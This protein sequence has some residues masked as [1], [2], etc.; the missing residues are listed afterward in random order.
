MMTKGEDGVVKVLKEAQN[1]SSDSHTKSSAREPLHKWENID[2]ENSVPSKNMCSENKQHSLDDNSSKNNQKEHLIYGNPSFLSRFI[3]YRSEDKV[4]CNIKDSQKENEVN[5]NIESSTKLVAFQSTTVV[6]QTDEVQSDMT[7]TSLHDHVN[8]SGTELM[9]D[10][11][12]EMAID[13]KEKGVGDTSSKQ[14]VKSSVKSHS[15]DST[16]KKVQVK[17]PSIRRVEEIRRRIEGNVDNSKTSKESK[18]PVPK[19]KNNRAD[20]KSKSTLD[21]KEDANKVEIRRNNSNTK[22]SPPRKVSF[23]VRSSINNGRISSISSSS[24]RSS[25]LKTAHM[26]SKSSNF[27]SSKVAALASKFNA[28]IYENKDGKLTGTLSTDSKRKSISTPQLSVDLP[29]NVTASSHN[30]RVGWMN[31]LKK[32]IPTEK[33]FISRRLSNSQKKE[34]GAI[35]TEPVSKPAL[36]PKLGRSVTKSGNVKAAIQ[37]FEKNSTTSTPSV[38]NT[39]NPSKDDEKS[40]EI[41][42]SELSEPQPDVPEVKREPNYPRVIFKRDSTLVRVTLECEDVLDS[43]KDCDKEDEGS[44]I[45]QQPQHEDLQRVTEI[46]FQNDKE[47]DVKERNMKNDSSMSESGYTKDVTV[48]RVSEQNEVKRPPKVKPAVPA[49]N[50]LKSQLNKSLL[51]L[52]NSMDDNNYIKVKCKSE[53]ASESSD[54]KCLPEN[55]VQNDTN[56]VPEKRMVDSECY[57]NKIY[58]LGHVQPAESPSVAPNKSFLWGISPPSSKTNV[59]ENTPSVYTAVPAVVT[60][61]ESGANE[62]AQITKDNNSIDETYDDVYPPSAIYATNS[63]QDYSVIEPQEDLYDDVGPPVCQDAVP[64]RLSGGI[65]IIR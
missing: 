27:S 31:S 5:T 9:K 33:T 40:L 54:T 2:G 60:K 55:E 19:L 51:D 47:I 63:Q 56:S 10:T 64:S 1:V 43:S 38:K 50:L 7:D 14:Y 11:L 30:S 52:N 65:I 8:N 4:P 44:T 39:P 48:D 6:K 42:K 23:K 16:A 49:K 35:G 29:K 20:S 53:K 46:S 3:E 21:S 45:I 32:P 62:S 36:Y 17:V 13:K 15:N 18:S 22:D 28:I 59:L 37:I 24:R 25:G 34:N 61:D 26:D 12:S 57:S 41:S 58:E